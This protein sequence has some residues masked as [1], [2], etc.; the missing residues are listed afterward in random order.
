MSCL[1]TTL[2]EPYRQSIGLASPLQAVGNHGSTARILLKI[3]F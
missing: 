3:V 2:R 1:G